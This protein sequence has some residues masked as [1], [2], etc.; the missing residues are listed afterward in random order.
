MLELTSAPVKFT[1]TQATQKATVKR[2]R[3]YSY[4]TMSSHA[5]RAKEKMCE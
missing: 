1:V 2:Q 4:R 3:T 5:E